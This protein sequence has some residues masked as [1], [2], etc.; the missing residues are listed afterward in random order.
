MRGVDFPFILNFLPHS[1]PPQ[2][3]LL[4]SALNY[5][6]YEDEP[7][8]YHPF[9]PFLP[10]DRIWISLSSVLEGFSIVFISSLSRGCRNCRRR[11]WPGTGV[12]SNYTNHRLPGGWI[13]ASGPGESLNCLEVVSQPSNRKCSFII[14]ISHPKTTLFG[15]CLSTLSTLIL[16]SNI[17]FDK[18]DSGD[19][20]QLSWT[21]CI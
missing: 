9:Q 3:L 1:G 7:V 6:Y 4:F 18:K 14:L 21:G 10:F 20:F 13:Q 15:W 17:Y 19:L 2:S 16:Q 5:H 12:A 11:V 8:L